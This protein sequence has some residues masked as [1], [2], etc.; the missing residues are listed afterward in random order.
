MRCRNPWKVPDRAGDAVGTNP[1]LGAHAGDVGSNDQASATN[2]H[3]RPAAPRGRVSG[4][5][6]DTATSLRRTGE[7]ERAADERERVADE[8]EWAQDRRDQAADE[9]ERIANERQALADRRERIADD[10]EELADQREDT[11]DERERE[12]D[13][14]DAQGVDRSTAP[15]AASTD[16]RGRRAVEAFERARARQVAI[17]ARTERNRA[18]LERTVADNDRQRAAI[19]REISVAGQAPATSAPQ[20]GHTAKTLASTTQDLRRQLVE[21]ALMTAEVEDKIARQ[22]EDLASRRQTGASD[23]ERAAEDARQGSMRAREIAQRF[24]D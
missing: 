23:F 3:D 20:S 12:Q 18:L 16:R 9:R 24:S 19:A 14:R 7:R 11:A 22:H 2:G 6:E 17:A 4:D 10:R 13:E 1:G 5:Q 8:R 21:A 15:E